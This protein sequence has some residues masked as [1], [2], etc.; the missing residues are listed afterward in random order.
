M[1][2]RAYRSMP[3]LAFC[4]VACSDSVTPVLELDDAAIAGVAEF[5]VA[6]LASMPSGNASSAAIAGTG[7]EV[8]NLQF[9]IAN[10]LP[11]PAGGTTVVTGSLDRTPNQSTRITSVAWNAAAVQHDCAFSKDGRTWTFTS[12]T[13]NA[14]G[15]ATF[16]FPA[17]PGGD[18]SMLT[19][20]FTRSGSLTIFNGSQSR[21]CNVSLTTTYDASASTFST[22]GTVCERQISNNAAPRGGLGG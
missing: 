15:N 7:S 19:L 16:A 12:G 4:L 20:S 1:S 21:T 17:Q 14:T 3:L 13:V 5:L 8:A 11:C 6:G 18:P 9:A 22:T 2:L 10:T